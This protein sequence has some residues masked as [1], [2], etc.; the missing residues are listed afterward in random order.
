MHGETREDK[1]EISRVHLHLL[2]C[3][4][5]CLKTLQSYLAI[6]PCI[7]IHTNTHTIT[8][9]TPQRYFITLLIKATSI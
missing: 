7:T 1:G 9:V 8:T 4:D 5:T 6:C 3:L 2:Y